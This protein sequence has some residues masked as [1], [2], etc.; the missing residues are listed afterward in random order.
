MY[1]SPRHIIT[2]CQARERIGSRLQARFAAR[3]KSNLAAMPSLEF[4]GLA[5]RAR[6]FELSDAGGQQALR[7]AAETGKLSIPNPPSARLAS[8]KAIRAV[9]FC[10]LVPG[11][12]RPSQPQSLGDAL[13]V[14]AIGG[15]ALRV[16]VI[17][18]SENA[19]RMSPGELHGRENPQRRP[20]ER[21]ASAGHYGRRIK[22]NADKRAFKQGPFGCSPAAP[23]V[24]GVNQLALYWIKANRTGADYAIFHQRGDFIDP[25]AHALAS[26]R[27]TRHN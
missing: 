27:A 21:P 20:R 23:R 3:H 24:L 9:F 22:R 2:A 26:K 15:D 7:P 18:G 16:I 6:R 13:G 19:S 1:R 4:S 11:R 25:G 17:G 14:I 10:V 12:P 8:D 5:G